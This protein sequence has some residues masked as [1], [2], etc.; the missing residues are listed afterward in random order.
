MQPEDFDSFARV[1]D[2]AYSLHS[3]SLTADARSLFF[4]ALGR[5][6]LAEVR[7]AFSAHISDPQ[8]GQYPPK[9]A[10]LIAQLQ[11]K[12]ASDGRPDADEAWAIALRSADEAD[13][14]VW[15]LECAEAFS[16]A[17]PVLEAGDE[18]GARM[19]FKAAYARIVERNR[20]AGQPARWFASLGFDASRR[21]QVIA[22]AVREGRLALTDAR[23]AVPL[24][25]AP[26]GSDGSAQAEQQL[27]KL[28]GLTASIGAAMERR[29]AEQERRNASALDELNAA[30]RATAERV[31][32]YERSH[33]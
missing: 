11:P 26:E 13:T 1:L 24:L 19:A 20:S 17:R 9:P 22:Q 15:T 18:V 31:A 12:V 25:G 3:K 14:V 4:A 7:K 30:K 27:A 28:R 32:E 29:A 8:R 23:A 16:A 10:D 6:S 5:Y 33:A 21:E 2:A